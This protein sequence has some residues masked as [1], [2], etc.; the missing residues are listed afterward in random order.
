MSKPMTV[1]AITSLLLEARIAGGPGVS[2]ICA[3][4]SQLVSCL[5]AA[6]EQGALGIISF[7]VAGGLAPHLGPGD[8]VIGSGVWTEHERY[9]ADRRWSCRLLEAIPGSVHAEIA[10]VD[11]PIAYSS[12][13]IR[14]H[15]RTGATAVDMESHIAAKIAALHNI[16]FAICRAVID[17]ADRDL[18][19]AAVVGLRHDGTPDVLAISRSIM[20][21]PN[22]V[23]AL[24]RTAIDAW[25]ARKALRWGRHLLGVG[26]S[27][28]YFNEPVSASAEADIFAATH[29]RSVGS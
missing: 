7:G 6:I 28:P 9:P 23:P 17:P 20:R 15:S 11:A 27:C 21:Q 24:V 10:G 3:H 14:L 12:E 18:P 25:T 1:I 4:A 8:W 22:Q 13:K 2:V 29:L 19:P 26:L 16:P 5:E